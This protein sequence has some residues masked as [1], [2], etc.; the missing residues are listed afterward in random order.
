MCLGFAVL[1][2]LPP[3]PWWH[4]S[5]RPHCSH[6]PLSQPGEPRALWA[7]NRVCEAA[8]RHRK[9]EQHLANLRRIKPMIDNRDPR[10]PKSSNSKGARLEE[11]RNNQIMHENT[12]LLNKLSRILTR[13]PEPVREPMLVR[14][15]NENHN[16]NERERIDRENQ[17]LLRRLQDVRP[18]I[19]AEATREQYLQHEYLITQHAQQFVPNPFLNNGGARPA[20]S[21]RGGS[22]RRPGS[23]SASGIDEFG[24]PSHMPAEPELPPPA[25]YEST[26][27][28]VEA[29][30]RGADGGASTLPALD[31]A[32]EAGGA[33]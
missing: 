4:G 6:V 23:A 12:I 17:A 16:K 30:L 10:R 18:S 31:E 24:E 1:P 5:S 27:A 28:D 9:H 19:D 13:D 14:G 7:S 20:S 11:E 21:S 3:H 29:M 32:A 25:S 33:S 8:V 26:L 22:A 15:L 2:A